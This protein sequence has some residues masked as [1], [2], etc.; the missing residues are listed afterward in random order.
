MVHYHMIFL[1]IL[2]LFVVFNLYECIDRKYPSTPP[3]VYLYIIENPATCESV[4]SDYISHALHQAKVSNPNSDV[5]FGSNIL[6]CSSFN[7]IF[8]PNYT[9]DVIFVDVQSLKSDKTIQFERMF[10]S[11]L[12][13]RTDSSGKQMF[14]QNLWLY[15]ALRFFILEDMMIKYDISSVIHLEGDNML[16]GDISLVVD[17]LTTKYGFSMVATPL[18]TR[19]I[20][21]TAS[22]L[23][24]PSVGVLNLYNDFVIK[25]VQYKESDHAHNP[26]TDYM[27]YLLTHGGKKKDG[28]VSMYA[29]NEMSMMGYYREKYKSRLLLF[30][31]IPHYKFPVHKFYANLNLYVPNNGI[32]SDL[33]GCGLFDSGSY[34]QFLDGTHLQLRPGFTDGNHIAGLAMRVTNGLCTVKMLCTKTFDYS[35]NSTIKKYP[36]QINKSNKTVGYDSCHTAPFVKCFNSSVESENEITV[37][38]DEGYFPLWNIHVHSKRTDRFVSQSCTC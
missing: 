1:H 21:I 18:N 33:L 2:L 6:N 38:A 25:I 27:D 8:P 7:S 20:F 35:K 34:G 16:Y 4:L 14:Q 37:P 11:I 26:W 17:E 24:V 22:I 29:I 3:I 19:I 30:P 28:T 15:S 31:V 13:T 12:K 5:I 9:N 10:D 23:W 32:T 36:Y